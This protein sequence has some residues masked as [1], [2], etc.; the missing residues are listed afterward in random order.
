MIFQDGFSFL[1]SGNSMSGEGRLSLALR[2][3]H[4]YVL[5]QGGKVKILVLDVR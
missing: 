3:T 4:D 2:A 5:R 1:F